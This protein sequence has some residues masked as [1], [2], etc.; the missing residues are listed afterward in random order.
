MY[1]TLVLNDGRETKSQKIEMNKNTISLL[2]ILKNFGV[3]QLRPGEKIWIKRLNFDEFNE[4]NYT[5][6][7]ILEWDKFNCCEIAI[8]PTRPTK[9]QPCA[10]IPDVKPSQDSGGSG[11]AARKRALEEMFI[12]N[13]VLENQKGIKPKK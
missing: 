10:D 1:V 13:L 5:M 7:S 3:D 8:S 2:E 11:S 4:K 12:I 9:P 6:Y